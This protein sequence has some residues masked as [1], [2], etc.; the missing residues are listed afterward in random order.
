MWLMVRDISRDGT[1]A[2][3]DNRGIGM[4]FRF[5]QEPLRTEE[6]FTKKVAYSPSAS[7]AASNRTVAVVNGGGSPSINWHIRLIDVASGQTQT[8][9][10]R[11]QAKKE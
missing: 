6:C 5:M 8:I 9:G 10:M 11:W 3:F 2:V 7:I 1:L 4:C